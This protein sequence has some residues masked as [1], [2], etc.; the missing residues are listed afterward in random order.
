[1]FHPDASR[2]IAGH[3]ASMLSAASTYGNVIV[4][5][6]QSG[7]NMI[8]AV[9]EQ[10]PLHAVPYGAMAGWAVIETFRGCAA[11]NPVAIIGG[12]VKVLGYGM[13]MFVR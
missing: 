12:L 11:R 9:V 2:F 4:P 5:A 10:C 8:A 13:L 1:M 6:I 3:A 7:C